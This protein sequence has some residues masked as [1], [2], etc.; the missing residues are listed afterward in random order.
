MKYR[1][2]DAGISSF[3]E[4]SLPASARQHTLE[5]LKVFTRYGIKV[6]AVNDKGPGPY[7]PVYN[8]TTGEKRKLVAL[9]SSRR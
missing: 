9:L 4:I 8:V 5:R 6:A 7:T 1:E 2:Q 3:I